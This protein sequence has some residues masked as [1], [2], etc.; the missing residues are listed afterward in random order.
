MSRLIS[1]VLPAP[2]VPTMAVRWPGSAVNETSFISG[3]SGSYPNFT[4]PKSTR[5]LI[6]SATR[7]GSAGSGSISSSSRMSNTR[8]T[9]AKADCRLLIMNDISVSGSE[10]WLMYWK[11]AWNVPIVRLPA[12]RKNP[13]ST[14]MNTCEKRVIRR[15]AGLIAFVMKSARRV[16]SARSCVASWMRRELESSWLNARMIARPE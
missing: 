14:A 8:S 1:V 9:E 5:P 11:K 6:G 16:V 13:P 10:A 15:M 7:S 3:R 4:C 12:T 2:V